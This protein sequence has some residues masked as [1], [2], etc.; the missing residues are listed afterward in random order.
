MNLAGTS[1]D[2]NEFGETE[3]NDVIIRSY[4]SIGVL[5]AL[6]KIEVEAREAVVPDR[7][8][9]SYFVRIAVESSGEYPAEGA[10]LISYDNLEK[11]ISSL[12]KLN[13][14]II[15]TTRFNF[16]EVEYEVEGLK[17]IA[18][19]DARGKMMFAVTASGVSAHFNQFT[20]LPELRDLIARA[21]SYLDQRNLDI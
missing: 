9:A 7:G 20:R 19:N 6:G 15:N 4:T 12:E 8:H 17:V 10:A 18:F 16:S 2:K 1:R 3:T 14:I 21:K 13:K 5:H 11:L